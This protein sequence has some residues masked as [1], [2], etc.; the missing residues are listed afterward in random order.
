MRGVRSNASAPP[1]KKA[2]IRVRGS[3]AAS[4]A[5]A[6][7]VGL[8]NLIERRSQAVIVVQPTEA[9]IAI[10]VRLQDPKERHWRK[11]LGVR[12]RRL[13]AGE[14]VSIGIA[15]ARAMAF[16]T[17][18]DDGRAA[19]LALGGTKHHWTLD[20]VQEAVAQGLLADAEAREGYRILCER[21][22]FW[23]RPWS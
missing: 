18:D 22:R 3:P 9:E 1:S 2:S 15:T 6:A 16:A 14:A 10:A 4:A 21:Y 8:D 19:Y 13:D 20:L 12:A 23:G 17:D 7:L 11:S 5:T